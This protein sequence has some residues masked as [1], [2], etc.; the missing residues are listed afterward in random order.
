[1]DNKTLIWAA[2]GLVGAG[3][4]IY[5]LSREE[6]CP[7]KF[8]P[9]KHTLSKLQ[10]IIEELRLDFTCIYV[11]NYNLMLK[12]IERGE[13]KPQMLSDLDTQVENELQE[14]AEKFI[15][16]WNF[17]VLSETLKDSKIDE[18]K[19]KATVKTLTG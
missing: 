11:R 5:L 9:A 8:N 14:K 2:L 15:A 6:T 12:M 1:M 16:Q 19:I 17:N 10:E 13:W 4:V 3:A 7:V 18:T